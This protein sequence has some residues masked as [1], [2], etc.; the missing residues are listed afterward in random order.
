MKFL[1][2][3]V[4]NTAFSVVSPNCIFIIEIYLLFIIASLLLLSIESRNCTR[5]MCIPWYGLL[6]FFRM[7]F[8]VGVGGDA[9]Q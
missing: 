1:E 9:L 8:C 4:V 2:L 3:C 5:K 6:K 7:R